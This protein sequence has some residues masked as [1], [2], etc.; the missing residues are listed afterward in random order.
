MSLIFKDATR[1]LSEFILKILN[2]N[3]MTE[4]EILRDA[5]AVEPRTEPYMVSL[6]IKSLVDSGKIAKDYDSTF[7]I[8]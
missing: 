8:L 3:A 2:G 6:A 4:V 5:C 7:Q 1:S